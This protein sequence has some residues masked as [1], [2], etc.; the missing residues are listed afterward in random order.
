MSGLFKTEVGALLFSA[1][2]PWPGSSF[3]VTNGADPVGLL[4]SFHTMAFPVEGVTLAIVN[5][6]VVYAPVV[7]LISMLLVGGDTLDRN[8]E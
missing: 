6:V 2:E 8:W 1:V 4:H 5:D 7:K 3:T